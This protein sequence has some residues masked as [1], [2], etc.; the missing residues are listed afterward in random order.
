M[1]KH[2]FNVRLFCLVV[3]MSH[4]LLIKA[5]EPNDPKVLVSMYVA[6]ERLVCPSGYGNKERPCPKISYDQ[7]RE[8]EDMNQIHG[9]HNPVPPRAI[10]LLQI[11]AAIQSYAELCPRTKPCD[12]ADDR[13]SVLMVFHVDLP[14]G[15][16]VAI[17][18]K[19]DN[20]DVIPPYGPSQGTLGDCGRW[21]THGRAD[22]FLPS[23][24]VRWHFNV[25]DPSSNR[26]WN[27]TLQ[28]TLRTR[29]EERTIK[30]PFFREGCDR[31]HVGTQ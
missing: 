28:T 9:I 26:M 11:K 5:Q 4:S 22:A 19:P 12:N 31:L 18:R 25:T 24:G 16:E 7:V 1:H 8:W 6:E 17:E 15:T 14:S 20:M 10:P 3:G 13:K 29:A 21:I 2:R 27:W 23:H 30:E